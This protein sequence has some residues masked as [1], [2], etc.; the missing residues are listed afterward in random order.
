MLSKNYFCLSFHNE[1]NNLLTQTWSKFIVMGSPNG[2]WWYFHPLI[3]FYGFTQWVLKFLSLLFFCL[4][5]SQYIL[6][7]DP[8]IIKFPG[9]RISIL[10][11]VP[12][13]W[14]QFH[15]NVTNHNTSINTSKIVWNLVF[16]KCY[17]NKKNWMN[18]IIILDVIKTNY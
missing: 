9:W 4:N 17:W 6:L 13:L 16:K 15:F 18:S 1:D 12:K 7:Y 3:F 14:N 10:I 11:I 2:P 8:G 5:S